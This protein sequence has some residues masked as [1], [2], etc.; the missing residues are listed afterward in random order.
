[1]GAASTKCSNPLLMFVCEARAGTIESRAMSE[2]S[3]AMIVDGQTRRLAPAAQ[4]RHAVATTARPAIELAIY[5]DLQ[6]VEDEWRRFEQS[7]DCTVFQTFDW[8]S[9]WHRHVGKPA[10]VIP[11]IVLGRGGDG[12]LLFLLPLAVVPGLVRRLTW[13]GSELCDYNA[14]LLVTGFGNQ[15]PPGHFRELWREI[16]RALQRR[17]PYRYD[18]VELT[19]MPEAVGTQVNPFLELDVGLN[20]SGAHLTRLYGTWEE[21]YQA[22]RSSATRRRDRTKRKRLAEFGEVRFFTPRDAN[23]TALTLDTLIEQKSK[24]FARMGVANLF[25]RPGCQDFF[26]DLVTNPRTQ[27][28]VHVSRLEVG[29]TRAAV[30]LGLT[31]RGC[32]YHVLASYDDGEISRFGPGAAHLR[33]LMCHAIGLGCHTFDFTIGDERYKT[34][35][36][37]RTINL[38]DHVAPA[39]ARGWPLAMLIL[40]SRRLKRAIKQNPLLWS[41]VSRLRSA[42][43]SKP[44]PA[45]DDASPPSNRVGKSPSIAPD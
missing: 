15:V 8:L 20:P 31:F 4:S 7:A 28:L 38:Y 21:F 16:C 24:S 37:D 5:D 39:S 14:P 26:L 23:D 6:A 40:T 19:K 29:S 27:H 33:D 32:Y 44:A 17:A 30:N 3:E 43:A 10:K 9:L 36:S 22:K 45:A 11:A 35:W 13:L 34:E 25:A 1:M 18:I 12:E 2:S 41:V 42:M